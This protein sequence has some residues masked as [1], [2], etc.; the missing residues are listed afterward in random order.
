[1][2]KW[3][4]PKSGVGLGVLERIGKNV[5][6]IYIYFSPKNW[7]DVV[8]WE[9]RANVLCEHFGWLQIATIS[10][11]RHVRVAAVLYIVC[12]VSSWLLALLFSR[13][14]H[15]G[16]V[17]VSLFLF[18]SFVALFCSFDTECWYD[19]FS[20]LL[21]F[22]EQLHCSLLSVTAEE[23]SAQPTTDIFERLQ[24][25]QLSYLQSLSIHFL[26]KCYTYLYSYGVLSNDSSA[27][28]SKLTFFYS[29]H[30]MTCYVRLG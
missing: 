6:F 4:N 16:T 25:A 18:C 22:I 14:V 13:H 17:F 21:F 28:I 3:R 10:W 29:L 19:H 12:C 30:D 23:S 11:F 8:T 24:S 20:S 7:L 1:M 2:T 15:E 5:K 27:S 26:P 9:R